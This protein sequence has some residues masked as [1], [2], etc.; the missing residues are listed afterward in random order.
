MERQELCRNWREAL[1]LVW[2]FLCAKSPPV[3]TFSFLFFRWG[4]Q[5]EFIGPDMLVVGA[6]SCLRVQESLLVGSGDTH[7]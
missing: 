2:V 4:G 6:Y 7:R 5:G 3:S 1:S